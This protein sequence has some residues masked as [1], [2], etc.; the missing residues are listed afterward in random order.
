[1]IKKIN[2]YLFPAHEIG[3]GPEFAGS[4]HPSAASFGG[5][6]K[7]FDFTIS[8]LDREY[9]FKVL[10]VGDRPKDPGFFLIMDELCASDLPFFFPR[11]RRIALL[12]ESAIYTNRI[13]FKLFKARF[14][15]VLTYR[16][17][18]LSKG[19]PFVELLYSSNFVY[20]TTGGIDNL[21]KI[22]LVSFIG[23]IQHSSS[24]EGYSI[25]REVASFLLQNTIGDCYGRGIKEILE[26]YEGLG[27][28]CFSVAMENLRENYYF[29]EKLIDC[30]LTETIPIYWGCPKIGEIFDVRGM[31]TFEDLDELK[32]ILSGLSF[33]KYEEMLPFAIEN[34]KSCLE[35]GLDSFK[36]Y[37]TRCV[38]TIE[39]LSIHGGVL[40]QGCLANKAVA[41][42]RKFIVDGLI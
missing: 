31:F 3:I 41:G 19:K 16:E 33:K 42:F 21:N 2:L 15:T 11:D 4:P 26:K 30:F 22:R 7:L 10:G 18:L 24:L 17:N 5:T 40:S 34:K 25:R 12:M 39:G 20:K 23:N 6:P 14:D 37:L 38:D 8:Q 9:L 35:K 29:T 1:M 32:L 36:S 28:Y 27:E 13:D